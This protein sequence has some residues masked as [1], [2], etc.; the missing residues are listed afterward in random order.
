MSEQEFFEAFECPS[1]T[2][3]IVKKV[4]GEKCEICGKLVCF[5]CI[6]TTED[7]EKGISQD[8]CDLCH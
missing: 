3:H 8:V 6:H 2:D 4:D 1:C 7:E 5:N